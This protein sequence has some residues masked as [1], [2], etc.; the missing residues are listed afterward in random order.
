MSERKPR[1]ED[2]IGSLFDASAYA[3]ADIA[4][5]A[6]QGVDLRLPELMIENRGPGRPA[7]EGTL[8]YGDLEA[9]GSY[10]RRDPMSPAEWKAMLSYR[11]SF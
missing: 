11:R 8:G 3:P 5:P 2:A 7:F 1:W 10:Q 9:R 4:V 6:P